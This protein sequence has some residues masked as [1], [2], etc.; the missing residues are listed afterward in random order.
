M[1]LA[2]GSSQETISKNIRTEVEA[3]KPQKQAIAIAME[4][5]GKSNKDEAS[6]FFL[7]G[8]ETLTLQEINERNRA[9]WEQKGGETFPNNG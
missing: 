1:P 9:L 5:A 6:D 2:E 7:A 8:P 3:G 4:K